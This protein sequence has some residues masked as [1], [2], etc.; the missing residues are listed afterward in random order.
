MLRCLHIWISLSL[1][2]SL[3]HSLSPLSHLPFSFPKASRS[4]FS[5]YF[6]VWVSY[7]VQRVC[8]VD[9]GE[10]LYCGMVIWALLRWSTVP[11]CRFFLI[12]RHARPALTHW[13]NTMF[14]SLVVFIKYIG[15][16]V[17][18]DKVMLSGITPGHNPSHTIC[19]FSLSWFKMSPIKLELM[20]VD[21]GACLLN[22]VCFTPVNLTPLLTEG[23]W[24]YL[25]DSIRSHPI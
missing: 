23:R 17:F 11:L 5:V 25:M 2:L 3:S 22:E 7:S 20:E 13:K 14:W 8:F 4:S 15:P 21:A 1:P 16:G 6:C 24:T 12:K 19:R 9:V 18:P 10:R